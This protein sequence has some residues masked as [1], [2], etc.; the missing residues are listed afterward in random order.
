M[1]GRPPSAEGQ[2]EHG[3]SDAED[4]RQHEHT[5]DD[6][7]AP[8]RVPSTCTTHAHHGRHATGGGRRGSP[9]AAPTAACP[10]PPPPASGEPPFPAGRRRAARPPAPAGRRRRGSPGPAVPRCPT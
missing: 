9:V 3:G 4:E 8:F 6:P 2:Q 5:C 1:T 7:P 10:A